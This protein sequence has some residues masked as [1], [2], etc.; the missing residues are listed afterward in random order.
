M[1]VE[2]HFYG[3]N[4]IAFLTHADSS[5]STPES[6]ISFFAWFALRQFHNLGQNP[7]AAAFAG[8]LCWSDVVGEMLKTSPKIP[9]AADLFLCAQ[10]AKSEENMG[11]SGQSANRSNSILGRL[12]SDFLS[13]IPQ[14]KIGRAHV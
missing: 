2:I 5:E 7:A 1:Q 10:L 11:A 13:S 14:I 4:Q 3:K 6:E 8:L 12:D 9:A